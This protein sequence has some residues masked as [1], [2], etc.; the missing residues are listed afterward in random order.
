MT[1]AKLILEPSAH[2]LLACSGAHRWVACPGSVRL[3]ATIRRVASDA[4]REG[5]VTHTIASSCGPERLPCDSFLGREVAV[6]GETVVVDQDMVDAA[7]GYLDRTYDLAAELGETPVFEER[8]DLTWL[9]QD[10]G[11]TSD[12]VIRQDFGVL[13]VRDLKYGF[14]WVDAKGNPQLMSYGLGAMGPDGGGGYDKVILDIDQPRVG[15]P[16]SVEMDPQDLIAWGHDVLRPA[17]ARTREPDAALAEGE[18]CRYCP[19]A[20]VCPKLRNS[21][22]TLVAV[23]DPA[24][25]GEFRLPALADLTPQQK[26]RI[27]MFADAITGFAKAVKADVE[28]GLKE[29]RYSP[30]EVGYKFVQ[31]KARRSWSDEASDEASVEAAAFAAGVDPRKPS[32]LLS[33]AALEKAFKSAHADPKVLAAFI[34]K[35]HGVSLAP[36]SDKRE[37]IAIDA[38]TAFDGCGE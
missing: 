20:S 4:S 38:N 25:G 30:H 10:M 15:D 22:S 14:A 7:Q 33:P 2:A 17:A 13:R 36:A 35:K 26:G 34:S 16:R 1:A 27:L 3:C 5:T 6:D 32:A 23:P 8:L 31:G 19:A 29:G 18:H 21:V 9:D 37:A 11:G 12:A 24:L 28:L